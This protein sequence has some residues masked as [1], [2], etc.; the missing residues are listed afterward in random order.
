M[1]NA[2]SLGA[3][4]GTLTNSGLVFHTQN[5]VNKGQERCTA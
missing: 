5:I 3:V 2:R 4:E 1:M